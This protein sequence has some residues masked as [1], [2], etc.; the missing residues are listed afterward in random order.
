[1][2]ALYTDRLKLRSLR[3]SDWEH[4][5]A[6]HSD[7][8]INLYVRNPEPEDVIRNKFIQRADTWFYGSGEWLT[9]VIE[10]VNTGQ[11]V[12]L[13]GLYCQ[14][15]EEQRAEVGYLL[16]K[17]SHGKGYATESL[18]AVID[19]ACLSFN[20]HKFIAHCAKDNKASARVL[21]KCGFQLEGLLRQHVKIGD[22]W[23]DDCAYGLLSDERQR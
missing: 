3:D 1:M 23:I 11:F 16:A 13:T 5:Y 4:F 10:T 15:I 6:L 18:K 21:E 19:W 9:L 12:G 17:Q 22:H 2:L 7:P 8:D 20:V 14:S